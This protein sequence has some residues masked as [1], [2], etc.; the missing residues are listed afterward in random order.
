MISVSPSSSSSSMWERC[1]AS[2][3]ASIIPFARLKGVVRVLHQSSL[4]S[5]RAKQSVKVPPISMSIEVVMSFFLL[6]QACPEGID[7]QLD[8]VGN[9]VTGREVL[10][11]DESGT[12]WAVELDDG[13]PLGI[14]SERVLPLD[15]R[16]VDFARVAGRDQAPFLV[17]GARVRQL[18]AAPRAHPLLAVHVDIE[19]FGNL[20]SHRCC[21]PSLVRMP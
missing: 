21:Y 12:A 6:P 19:V 7:I 5:T 2:S 10:G 17:V 14:R 18:A 4:P 13:A 9:R 8:V 16:G 11:L 1:A 15:Y 3:M 20:H